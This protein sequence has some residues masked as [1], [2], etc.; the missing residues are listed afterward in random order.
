M[1]ANVSKTI[2]RWYR[3]PSIIIDC[4]LHSASKDLKNDNDVILSATRRNIYSF[5]Y[6]RSLAKNIEALLRIRLT[7]S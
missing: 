7:D 4:A 1:P 3:L 2:H 6:A 5:D